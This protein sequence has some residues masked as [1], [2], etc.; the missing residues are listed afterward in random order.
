MVK[1]KEPVFLSPT[2]WGRQ[3]AKEI[4]TQEPAAEKAFHVGGAG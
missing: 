2:R 3:L 4:A 1:E